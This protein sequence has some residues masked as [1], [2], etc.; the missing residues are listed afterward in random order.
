MSEELKDIGQQGDRA[1]FVTLEGRIGKTGE[2]GEAWRAHSSDQEKLKY[3]VKLFR[4]QSAPAG[5]GDDAFALE[6]SV[7]SALRHPNIVRIID[8][9]RVLL[10][11]GMEQQ[12]S[13]YIMES[14]GDDVVTL[15]EA[16]DDAKILGDRKLFLCLCTLRNVASAL[17]YIHQEGYSHFDIKDSNV[18]ISNLGTTLPQITLID[19]GFARPSVS[20]VTSSYLRQSGPQKWSS[21]QW[22]AK[23]PISSENLDVFQLCTMV[24]KGIKGC[25]V[26][27]EIVSVEST[28]DWPIDYA[29]I[30]HL[31]SLLEKWVSEEAEGQPAIGNAN[32]FFD[33][34][35]RLTR[36]YEL[37]PDV[38]GAIAYLSIPEIATAAQISRAFEAMRIPPRELVLYTE[39]IKKLI[40][41]PQFC[42]LR[43]IRQLGFTHLV[44]PG[45]QGTRFEHSMGMYDLACH[46]V[47]RLSGHH[48]FRRECNN[49]RDILKFVLAALLHDVGHFP[50]AHQI[51]EFSLD[52]FELQDRDRVEG[53]LSGHSRRGE[54]V[55]LDLANDLTA[56]FGLNSTDINDVRRL[57]CSGDRELGDDWT[58]SLAFLHTLIDG[59]IDLDKLD[60]IERDAF[61]CGVPYGAFLDVKRIF[62]TMRIL[63][64]NGK[65]IF[66]FDERAIGSLEQFATA[67]H[68]L[69]ANVYWHR[70]VRSATVMFKHAFYLFQQLI[71]HRESLEGL[72]YNTVSD[73]CL[74][75]EIAQIT[76]GILKARGQ[77]P[78]I[79]KQGEAVLALIKVVSGR[80]RILFKS[81]LERE[82][83]IH[84][85]EAP[86]GGAQ[87]HLQR[88]RAKEIFDSLC[89]AGFLSEDAQKIGEHN[90]LIDGHTDEFPPFEKITVLTGRSRTPKPLPTVAP[91]VAHLQS[92]FVQQ[93]C[94]IRV[95][96]NPQVLKP[97]FQSKD[98]RVEVGDFLQK[99][100]ELK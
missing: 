22:K 96:V 20:Q 40:T 57:A 31:Q 7:L 21:I 52:D 44:Y 12:C 42:A 64:G 85:A 94:K 47:I 1:H 17:V 15:A 29:A 45:A 98:G 39:R 4:T 36:G 33:E 28:H 95:F 61:H 11:N 89:T 90:V 97:A 76:D 65:P 41:T 74:L 26:K 77:D 32:E 51:E 67:R 80:E 34:L 27:P 71:A 91:S 93:A 48:A 2:Q 35:G 56:S 23:A 58:P 60:Y 25:G 66:A 46:F 55:I 37:A 92:S 84:R 13:F 50:F 88:V 82:R 10:R 78:K 70:A 72:F 86:F 14:L 99:K 49:E 83:T 81:I 30:P 54:K 18:L 68:E 69:Y 79:R 3:V 8:S 38:K 63:P 24:T 43:Y 62:E 19:F 9:G 73:D 100:L 87:Y 53:L 59:P 5:N 6:C 16:L 75:H